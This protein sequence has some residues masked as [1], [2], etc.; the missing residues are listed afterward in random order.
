M[1][2]P[3]TYALLARSR[4]K[5]VDIMRL[6]GSLD[7]FRWYHV[8]TCPSQA[9]AEILVRQLNLGARITDK[10][11]AKTEKTYKARSKKLKKIRP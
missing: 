6:M 11:D 3:T 5:A 7:N 1:S 10:E 8:A 9:T 4:T 2:T